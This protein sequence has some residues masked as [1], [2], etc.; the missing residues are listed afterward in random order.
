MVGGG[1]GN[2]IDLT[3]SDDEEDNGRG[4]GNRMVVMP[5]IVMKK[6][7]SYGRLLHFL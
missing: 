2:T 5:Q 4:N 6:V 1:G 3:N 7:N